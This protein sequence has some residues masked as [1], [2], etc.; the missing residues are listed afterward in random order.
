MPRWYRSLCYG[1]LLGPRTEKLGHEVRLIPPSYV[2]PFVRR[3][4]KN[5]AADAAAICE[6]VRRPDMRFVPIKSEANQSFLMLH[7]ARGLLVRQRTMTVCHPRSSRRI[8]NHIQSRSA[9]HRN[10]PADD[11]WHWGFVA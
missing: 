5:D 1:T 3:G 6:A 4:A 7:R 9:A 11:R 10:H 2:K 8:R